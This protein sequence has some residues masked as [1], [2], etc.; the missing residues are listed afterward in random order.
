MSTMLFDAA[1][2]NFRSASLNP[3]TGDALRTIAL[4]CQQFCAGVRDQESGQRL[5]FDT[6]ISNLSNGSKQA[7]TARVAQLLALGLQQFC[8]GV[9]ARD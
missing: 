8:A 1:I 9:K 6:A 3:N 2:S 5:L 4:A 7:D